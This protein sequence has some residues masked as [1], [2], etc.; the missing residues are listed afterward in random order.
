MESLFPLHSRVATSAKASCTASWR[1]LMRVTKGH[2]PTLNRLQSTCI[3]CELVHWM[4]TRDRGEAEHTCMLGCRRPSCTHVKI[5]ALPGGDWATGGKTGENDSEWERE[6]KEFKRHLIFNPP[7]GDFLSII[8]RNT[9]T[10]ACEHK[11]KKLVII[12][13]LL[14]WNRLHESYG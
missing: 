12:C 3:R 1:G 4:E 5:K 8:Q 10:L 14:T 6:R 2:Q 13:S 11:P 7:P 9:S